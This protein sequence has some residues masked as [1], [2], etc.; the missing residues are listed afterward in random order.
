MFFTPS[1]ICVIGLIIV[2][3]VVS[4]F[5]IKQKPKHAWP[6]IIGYW[7]LLTIKNIFDLVA[8]L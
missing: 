2:A 4:I 3:A 6:W 7:I 1:Q 5:Q 8:M